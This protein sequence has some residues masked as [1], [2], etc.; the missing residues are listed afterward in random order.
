MRQMIKELEEKPA[1]KK[2]DNRLELHGMSRK[3]K[4]KIKKEQLNETISEMEPKEKRKYL[5]YYYKERIIF[6]VIAL[7]VICVV[8]RTLYL[9]SRPI[10]LSYV[11]INCKNQLEFNANAI[12]EYAKAINKYEGCQIKGDTNV[13]ALREEYA[14]EY[15][16]NPNSQQYIN[17]MTMA[18]AD[19]Y[20][21]IFTDDEGAEYCASEDIFYPINKYL[22]DETYNLVK[23]DIVLYKNMEGNPAEMVIDVS[24]TDFAKSLN[25]GYDKIYMG[26][27]G[28]E[29]RNHTAVRDLLMYIYK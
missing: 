6:S 21:V 28:D 25:V 8:G 18:T 29:E 3:E 20:D 14:N 9:N 24:D 12:D 4:R 1:E 22:D 23:D 15:E 11:V 26:F 16:G 13:T 2:E 17:F 7:V 10:T 27:P 19:L 5:L